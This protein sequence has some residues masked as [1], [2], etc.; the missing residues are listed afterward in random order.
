MDQRSAVNLL[1]KA[2]VA[3]TYRNRFGPARRALEHALRLQPGHPN[4][5]VQLIAVH[6]KEGNLDE[7]VSAV[8][9]LLESTRSNPNTWFRRGRLKLLQGDKQSGEA[10]FRSAL[11]LAPGHLNTSL[12]LASLRYDAGSAAEAVEIMQD[13]VAQNEEQLAALIGLARILDQTGDVA[14]VEELQRRAVDLG[15]DNPSGLKQLV[16]FLLERERNDEAAK[17]LDDYSKHSGVI[18]DLE[19]RLGDRNLSALSLS[20]ATV[21]LQTAYEA[22][23]GDFLLLEAYCKGLAKQGHDQPALAMIEAH[24]EKYGQSA[25]A[26]FLR[27]DISRAEGDAA[28]AILKKAFELRPENK[29]AGLRLAAFLDDQRQYTAAA[30]TL[31]RLLQTHLR[32]ADLHHRLGLIELKLRAP[33]AAEACFQKA[34]SLEPGHVA[35]S[36]L[37][38]S[39]VRSLG[40]REE[41]ARLFTATAVLVRKSLP[42]TFIDGLRKIELSI[43]VQPSSMERMEQG[44]LPARSSWPAETRYRWGRLVTQ[45]VNSWVFYNKDSIGEILHFMRPFDWQALAARSPS[46]KG[47]VLASAHAGVGYLALACLAASGLPYSVV[48]RTDEVLLAYDGHCI[49]ARAGDNHTAL[50]RLSRQV[51][52]EGAFVFTAADGGIGK[53]PKRHHNQGHS[54]GINVGPS[55]LS[56]LTKAPCYFFMCVVEDSKMRLMVDRFPDVPPGNIMD[57]WYGTWF[58]FF[59]KRYD[60]TLEYGPENMNNKIW[61]PRQQRFLEKVA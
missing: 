39:T 45:L 55:V 49:D 20:A 21:R 36:R 44:L 13:C 46:G 33:E 60:A 9:L 32:D 24:E 37:L 30:A 26:Q 53:A 3:L 29:P 58:D 57:E 14:G 22:S 19:L 51:G 27:L 31:K 47:G 35:A 15:S 52:R 5:L 6:E 8:D 25:E 50:A 43:G 38:T 48:G 18:P 12:A 10:D 41:A 7:A 11:E 34:L 1:V 28:L 61:L 56:Y 40:R 16:N 54:I 42:P 2:A 23:K 59:V 17:L 4:S